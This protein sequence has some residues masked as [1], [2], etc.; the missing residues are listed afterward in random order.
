MLTDVQRRTDEAIV[1]IF[2]TGRALGNYGQVTL[3]KGDS[4]H[5]TYGRS[6]TTL[7]SGNLFLLVKAYCNE[8]DGQFAAPL[9]SYLDRMANRDTTLDT[10]TTL[11]GLLREAG[12]DPVMRAVQDKF[13]D[14]VYWVP[15]ANDSEAI[16]ISSALGTGVVYDSH[17]HGAWRLVR[18]KTIK[19]H[20]KPPKVKE[21]AWIGFYVDVRRNWLATHP[22]PALHRTVYR[23]DA[24]KKLIDAKKWDLALPI[25][26]RGV[27]LN[28][29][30]LTAE[31]PTRVSAHDESERT[32]Q[33]QTPF[34]V[35]DDVEALQRALVKAGVAVDVD[36]IYGHLTEA[37]VRRFQQ[38]TGLTPDGI[39][40]PATR[41]ALGL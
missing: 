3:I 34:M 28:E 15:S 11:R 31:R 40:G 39:L 25:T 30:V 37:A 10:D 26:V 33:L 19:K 27:L 29:D 8:P 21:N 41:S 4:G 36:G 2:E 22:N 12:D 20:G 7:A 16:N 17:I 18:D 13:F 14:R 24:F 9:R 23:M 6:Q 38:K 32:L 35:G 5:L 1:N